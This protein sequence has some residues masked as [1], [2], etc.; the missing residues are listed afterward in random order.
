MLNL[1]SLCSYLA[2]AFVSGSCLAQSYNIV[3]NSPKQDSCVKFS[4]AISITFSGPLPYRVIGYDDMGHVFYNQLWVSPPPAE[5]SVMYDRLSLNVPD[6][7][8][9][10]TFRIYGS[11]GS[12]EAFVWLRCDWTAPVPEVTYPAPGEFVSGVVAIQGS[13]ADNYSGSGE[14]VVFIDGSEFARGQGVDIVVPWDTSNLEGGSVHTISIQGCDSCDNSGVSSPVQVRIGAR[15]MGQ[16]SLAGWQGDNSVVEF[17]VTIKRNGVVEDELSTTL[18]AAGNY[19]VI[20][21]KVG[22]GADIVLKPYHWCSAK[23]ANQTVTGTM[24]IDMYFPVNGD[25]TNDNVVGIFDINQLLSD[26]T[27]P[28]VHSDLD[29][30]GMVDI[31]DLNTICLNFSLFGDE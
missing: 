28:E 21:T 12:M 26:W 14:W 18:D 17:F 24:N 1:R 27:L 11:Q 16:V 23:V 22:P 3:I 4:T 25:A 7:H 31:Y 13:L 6:G 8:H 15:I 5:V 2:L 29:G 9:K 10:V 30:T 20:T 19:S